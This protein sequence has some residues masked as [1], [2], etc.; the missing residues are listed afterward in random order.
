MV[1]STFGR[2]KELTLTLNIENP[3]R[4]DVVPVEHAYFSMSC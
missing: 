4:E 1:C 3:P 2:P